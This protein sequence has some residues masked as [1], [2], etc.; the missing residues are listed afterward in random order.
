[1]SV[2]AVTSSYYPVKFRVSL[3]LVSSFFSLAQLVTREL[4]TYWNWS[5]W[6]RA[7]RSSDECTENELLKYHNIG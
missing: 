4:R 6:E 1:M 3:L 7:R 5:Y 2:L